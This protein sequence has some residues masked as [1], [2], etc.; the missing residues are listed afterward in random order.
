M[1]KNKANHWSVVDI[2]GEANGGAA[3]RVYVEGLEIPVAQ[4]SMTYGLNAIPSATA[5]IA[6]GRNA[7]TQVESTIYQRVES[8]KQMAEVTVKVTGNLGDWAASGGKNN[9]QQKFP[10]GPATIFVGYVA[11]ISYRRAAGRVSMALNMINRLVDLDMSAGGSKDVVPGAPH[12]LMLPTL[13]RGS[14]GE[15]AATAG[16]KFVLQLPND[17][18]RDFS[19][20]VLTSLL[21]VAKNNQIQTHKGSLWC[22]GL[23]PDNPAESK[24]SN[25][26][27]IDAINGVG[28]DWQ[29][30][31]GIAGGSVAKYAEAYPLKVPDAGLNLAS[32]TIGET[33]AAS[34]AGT[35]MW[36]MMI[37]ALLPPFGCGIVPTA[38]GAI[39]APILNNAR[40]HRIAIDTSDYADF[41][42][43][44]MSKRPL[45]GVG[46]LGTYQFGTL[47]T[48]Q[49]K[50]CVGATFTA[51]V[52]QDSYNDGMW[53]FVGAPSWME[54]WTNFDPKALQGKAD[55]NTILST[56]S[57]DAV[58]TNTPAITR[59]P[60]SEVSGWAGVMSQYA[61]LV[62][63]NNSLRGREG[64]L[65]GKLRFDIAPGTTVLVRSNGS[66]LASGVDRM[67]CDMFA[68]VAQV[69]VTINAEQASA[70]TA[71]T[72]TNIRTEAE[73]RL[74][75]FS[76]D[77]HPF[78]DDA[79]FKYAPLVPELSLEPQI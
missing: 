68:F 10:A 73:N 53:M 2:S 71:L 66:A 39:L 33:I 45:Y 25:K 20:G 32:K 31:A 9:S 6:L 41:D 62:Y 74:T 27:A 54:D 36:N 49:Q 1:P 69:T 24:S 59:N 16:T 30:I 23:G 43:T 37:G 77:T 76:M 28:N 61:R 79:Y 48:G 40:T 21:Y 3:I 5:L 65:V 50:Q 52:T 44:M 8:I 55:V 47:A 35:S 78:F 12:D 4:F 7:R 15:K 64:T 72:L 67:A 51:P 18:R 38:T 22:K 11:G 19:A 46:V 14:G 29:G 57:H 75:R 58:G 63:A 60:E 70:A 13:T 56:P 34:L 17:I 42:M 26:R